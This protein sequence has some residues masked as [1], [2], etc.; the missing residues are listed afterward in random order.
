MR[1]AINCNG[2]FAACLLLSAMPA[3]APAQDKTV[4]G[5]GLGSPLRLP[6][7]GAGNGAMTSTTCVTS[8]PVER[9]AWGADEHH[10]AIPLSG[11]PPYARGEFKVVTVKGI[12]ES[13][14]IATWGIQSQSVALATLTGQYGKPAR[15]RQQKLP[16]SRIP[17]EFAEWDLADL[18]INF[19]GS[20]GSI[21]WGLVDVST[22]RYRRLVKDYEQ[23]QPA[24]T[25][26]KP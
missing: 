12:V 22:P 10:V 4:L 9:K 15:T 1:S 8:D 6:K 23:R 19:Q 3:P 20:T 26:R 17:A 25:A 13:V 21:D 18:S 24:G 7:C 14:Q 11:A 5:I 16:L 2:L